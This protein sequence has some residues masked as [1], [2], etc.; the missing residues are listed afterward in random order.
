LRWVAES[1]IPATIGAVIPEP[2][3]VR[4]F[5][6]A[7]AMPRRIVSRPFIAAFG[8]ALI[9]SV[10][11]TGPAAHAAD[12]GRTLPKL[13]DGAHPLDPVLKIAR[14]GLEQIDRDVRDYE[15]V[16]IKRERIN[17]ELGESQ[18]MAAK[19]RH[20]QTHGGQST[21]FS[22][23]LKFLKPKS[24]EGREVIWVSGRNDNKL[25]AHEAGLLNFKRAWLDP[26]G[27]FAMIGQRYP[28]S[29]IGIR[30]MV[31]ELVKKGEQDRQHGE[32]EVKI[33]QGAKVD[34]RPCRM[35]QVIHP[36]K[37][38]HFEF[39]KVQIF[40]DDE[41]NLPIRYASWTWP[42]KPGDE[43]VLEEEYTY[44]NIRLNVGLTDED[45]DPDNKDYNFPRL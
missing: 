11:V 41:L 14:D 27:Y 36:V 34:D 15:C 6:T 2:Q 18:Y 4:W 1:R 25:V 7:G 33:F 16:I 13:V 17:G 39:H 5:T 38:P 43:P 30:F 21:P 31:E 9:V 8:S 32:C 22:V 10:L 23:Y 26:N 28:I 29:H 45:F 24:L 44:R 42:V 35:I 40:I 37:R 3:G 12:E 20:E 19:V